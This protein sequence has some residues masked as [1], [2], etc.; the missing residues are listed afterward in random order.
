MRWASVLL[1]AVAALL[2]SSQART[3]DGWRT[4]E[5]PERSF[6]VEMP[7]QPTYQTTP[8]Q[9]PAGPTF[10]LHSYKLTAGSE[11]F[12]V[13]TYLLQPPFE[14]SQ[15]RTLL[16]KLVDGAAT[17]LVGQKWQKTEWLDMPNITAIATTGSGP[18]GQ[19]LRGL[20]AIKGSRVFVLMFGGP[21]GSEV[22][23]NAERFY[24]SF[25]IR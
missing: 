17:A 18:D 24:K 3:Q 1:L 11:Q 13:Q 8:L 2:G 21:P 15:P 19:M 20:F 14:V 5:G 25:Q 6:V 10:T 16:Q 4:I 23:A 12:G 22:G 7:A 9:T